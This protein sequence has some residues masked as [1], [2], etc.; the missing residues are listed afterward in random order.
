MYNL[1]DALRAKILANRKSFSEEQYS[2]DNDV[3]V[4]SVQ[5]VVN[6]LQIKQ[7]KKNVV[8]LYWHMR[9]EPDITKLMIN[10]V[11]RIAIPKLKNKKM[12][13]VRYEVGSPIEKSGFGTLMQPKSDNITE[14]DIVVMPA[15]A[16]GINGYRLGFGHG[17]YDRY[18]SSKKG[19]IKIGTCFDKDLYE[20]LPHEPHDIKLDYIITE[21]TIID[22]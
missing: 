13:F 20:Y 9:G 7:K 21:K 3:I 15:L 17:H 22:L 16:F 8:G 10:S 1:K 19:V 2:C 11:W 12:D 5:E 14:I 6:S 4:R 18:L